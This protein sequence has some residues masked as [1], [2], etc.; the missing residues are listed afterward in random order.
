MEDE[1]SAHD[2][3]GAGAWLGSTYF[4]VEGRGGMSSVGRKAA[5]ATLEIGR[6]DIGGRPLRNPSS[7]PSIT[8]SLKYELGVGRYPSGDGGGVAA[9]LPGACHACT[10]GRACTPLGYPSIRDSL[11]K[12]LRPGQPLVR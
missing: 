4:G 5:G 1:F 6:F 10:A 2:R 11:G 8:F 7:H 3:F 12:N 9:D